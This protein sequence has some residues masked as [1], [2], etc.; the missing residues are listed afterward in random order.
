[1]YT[2]EGRARV[3]EMDQAF[4]DAWVSPGGAA[5]LLAVTWF[6]QRLAGWFDGGH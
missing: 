4:I 1:M 5:D 2:E 6:V 3:R